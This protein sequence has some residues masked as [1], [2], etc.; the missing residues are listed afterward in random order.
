MVARRFSVALPGFLVSGLVMGACGPLPEDEPPP[1]TPAVPGTSATSETVAIDAAADT[2]ADTDPSAL[3]DFH[4]VLDAHGS[5]VEDPTYGTAWVPNAA[6]VGA[7]F[8]PYETAGH[9]EYDDTDYVWVSD[10]DWGWAPFHYGR[11]MYA[12]VGW[13]WI[14][15]RVYSPAWVTWR[16]GEPGYAYVGWAPAAAGF[17]WRGGV[18]VQLA[19]VV[20]APRGFYYCNHSEL[21]ARNVGEHVVANVEVSAVS[22]HT[23]AYGGVAIG[24]GAARGPA[25]GALGIPPSEV[26]RASAN[27]RGLQMARSFARPSTAK[28]MGGHPPTAHQVVTPR[29]MPSS[30][31]RARGGRGGG[32]HGGH[33]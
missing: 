2:Y 13:M 31:S 4:P 1:A 25:P 10:Y 19:P 24:G 3:T 27:N 9:W 22:A 29:A 7:G 6:E 28:A 33:R 32:G 23:Q 21:F 15:G 20:V 11:W 17:Y 18:A 12:S 16:I 30:H 8:A 14:P 26:P 5:W